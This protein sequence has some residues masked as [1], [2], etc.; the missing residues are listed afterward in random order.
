MMLTAEQLMKEDP[1]A[2]LSEDRKALWNWV[3]PRARTAFAIA[4]DWNDDDEFWNCLGEL[5]ENGFN[6]LVSLGSKN[7]GLTPT[8]L[9]SIGVEYK[10]DM[11]S[12]SR[13]KAIMTEAMKAQDKNQFGEF[14]LKH[15]VH[16]DRGPWKNN[17]RP[18]IDLPESCS[19]WHLKNRKRKREEPIEHND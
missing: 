9:C 10:F 6:D 16:I 4:L 19:S 18:F 7:M 1:P 11:G 13:F 14:L 8:R 12:A 5:Q 2:D 17:K 15:G 3:S